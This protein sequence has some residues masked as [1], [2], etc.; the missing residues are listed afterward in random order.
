M[1]SMSLSCC[2]VSFKTGHSCSLVPSLWENFNSPHNHLAQN[3]YWYAWSRLHSE[4]ITVVCRERE[5]RY[6]FLISEGCMCF[7]FWFVFFSTQTILHLLVLEKLWGK[8]ALSHVPY[9]P[10]HNIT[11]LARE[12]NMLTHNWYSRRVK[13]HFC[14]KHIFTWWEEKKK[15]GLRLAELE[16]RNLEYM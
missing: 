10:Q 3:T 14:S 7:V 9:L 5:E 1:W 4:G 8:E 13:G 12:I 2:W 15:D 16:R 11:K 6:L